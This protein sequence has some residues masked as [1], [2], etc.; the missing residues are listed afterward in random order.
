M[1]IDQALSIL[2]QT[3]AELIKLETN[4][5]AELRQVQSVVASH[6]AALKL[7]RTTG[8][9]ILDAVTARAWLEDFDR[10]LFPNQLAINAASASSQRETFFTFQ[11][12]RLAADARELY[13]R[14]HAEPLATAIQAVL[15]AR[16]RNRDKWR[17]QVADSIQVLER[18]QLLNEPLT[19]DE[20]RR[21]EALDRALGSQ[22]GIFS[23]ANNALRKFIASQRREDFDDA[24]RLANQIDYEVTP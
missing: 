8:Q 7:F 9:G 17:Q 3:D 12:R 14:S 21:L 18:R 6:E 20:S 4:A 10:L 15:T 16:S 5:T 19:A 11:N 22:D 1:K 23:E 13:T 24:R 2:E